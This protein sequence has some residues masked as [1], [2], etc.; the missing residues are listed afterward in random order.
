MPKKHLLTLNQLENLSSPVRLAIVQRLEMDREATA[1]ELSERMGRP[2]TALYHHLQQ[3]E[4]VGVLRV[5]GERK[6]PRRPEAI[7]A[8][9]ADQLST[10]DV[11]KTRK[12]R[13][14][15]GQGAIRVADAGSR[16]FAR[17]MTQ[18]EPRFEGSQRN[19]MVRYFVLRANKAKL[20]ELN[21]LIDEL[22]AA[23]S[24]PGEDGEEIQLTWILTPMPAK[25]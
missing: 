6:G 16:A 5:V 4:D 10:A 21:R 8:L 17:A 25:A 24:D 9:V 1:R 20:A 11:V 22:D 23:A 14:T 19:A 7:Y 12:G 3:L 15:L 13:E 2:V 18:M